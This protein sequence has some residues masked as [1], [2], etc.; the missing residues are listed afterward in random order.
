MKRITFL[1]SLAFFATAAL[2]QTPKSVL[3]VQGKNIATV[4]FSSGDLAKLPHVKVMAPR[5]HK[6]EKVEYEGIPLKI[7]LEKAAVL[8]AEKPLHGKQLL[9]YV[10]FTASDGYRVVFSLAELEEATGATT[11][12]ILADKIAGQALTEKETPLQ[13]V[14]PTD[15]RPE[16]YAR[17]ITSITVASVE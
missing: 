10:V 2:A 14:V 15:K 7:I 11:G 4:T 12:V 8:N 17:M 3:T 5:G 9:Q 13:L 16:R 6:P 1:L